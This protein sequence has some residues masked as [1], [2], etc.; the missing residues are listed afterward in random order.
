MSFERLTLFERKMI[1]PI[2]FLS[3]LLLVYWT[4]LSL[5]S[6]IELKS[7]WACIS[8]SGKMRKMHIICL[9]ASLVKVEKL[10]KKLVIRSYAKCFFGAFIYKTVLALSMCCLISSIAIF[11]FRIVCAGSLMFLIF[12]EKWLEIYLISISFVYLS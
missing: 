6:L 12:P 7:C 4:N 5:P 2:Y 9:N 10:C 11:Y 3:E 8:V 1:W